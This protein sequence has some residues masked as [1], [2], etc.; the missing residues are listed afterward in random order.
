MGKKSLD[1]VIWFQLHLRI[2]ISTYS[3]KRSYVKYRLHHGKINNEGKIYSVA[4]PREGK[5][6]FFLLENGVS[7]CSHAISDTAIYQWQKYFHAFPSEDKWELKF[8][9]PVK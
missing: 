3:T 9:I 2:F 5:V 8:K 6:F 1:Y 4:T 7:R